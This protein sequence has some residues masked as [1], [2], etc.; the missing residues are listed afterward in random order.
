[1]TTVHVNLGRALLRHP[2][3]PRRRPRPPPRAMLSP[4]ASPSSSAT[5]T[6]SRTPASRRRVA[7]RRGLPRRGRR[8]PRRRGAE[9][10]RPA[11]RRCTT[12]SR[13][14]GADRK[15]LVVAVGGGVVGDLAGF[16]AATFNRGLPLLMVPTTLLAMVDSSRRRQG[17]RQPPARQEPHRR[18]PPAGRRLDRHRRRS[19]RCPTASTAAAWPR[20]SSTASSSTPSSSPT[21][22][23]TSTRSWRATRKRCAHI[24]ARSC[25]LKADVV[26][27]DEREE[28]GPA[29][30]AELR[31]H[32]RPRLRDGRR[33]RRLAARRG[34]G[35]RHGRAPAGWPSGAG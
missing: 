32:V 10:P 4:A 34:G 2:P 14:C 22:R 9:V 13:T 23:R 20:S 35:G 28:T 27:Q 16:V 18:V 1:M 15:T 26:E 25:R 30:G 6:R 31:P 24:V 17:R 29:G 7:R 3:R 5:H 21:W 19:T 8:H 11:P 12:G 33:L